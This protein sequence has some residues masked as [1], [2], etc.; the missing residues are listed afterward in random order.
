[1]AVISL[2]AGL[3]GFCFWGIGGIVAIV[4]GHIAISQLKKPDNQ[5]SG[6]GFAVA[7]LCLG[8]FQIAAGIAMVAIVFIAGGTVRDENIATDCRIEF[9][10]VKTAAGAAYASGQPAQSLQDLVDF[11]YLSDNEPLG[12]YIVNGQDVTQVECPAS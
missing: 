12:T 3:A 5:Q 7:G 2:V 8:Y 11:G 9:R 6:R 1:M 4:L 10:T